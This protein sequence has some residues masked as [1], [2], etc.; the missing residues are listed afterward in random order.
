MVHWQYYVLTFGKMTNDQVTCS[1]IWS[2]RDA[3][4][5][6]AFNKGQISKSLKENLSTTINTLKDK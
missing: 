6:G 3:Q 5:W 1:L 4:N 2:A